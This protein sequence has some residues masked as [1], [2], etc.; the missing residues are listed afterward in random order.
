MPVATMLA[1]AVSFWGSYGYTS[2]QP[3]VWTWDS[4]AVAQQYGQQ[5][6][7]AGYILQGYAPTLRGPD[8]GWVGIDMIV[9]VRSWWDGASNEER[10]AVVIHEE[11]HAAFS[12]P[13]TPNGIMA[14]YPTERPAPGTCKRSAAAWRKLAGLPPL[15]PR[16]RHVS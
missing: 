13:H 11:G 3:A 10:C 8:G 6:L 4:P 12:F 5:P 1:I 7:P 2:T 16:R 15:R 14:Q 9:L